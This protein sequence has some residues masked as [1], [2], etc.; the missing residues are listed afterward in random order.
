MGYGGVEVMLGQNSS[1]QPHRALVN[2]INSIRCGYVDMIDIGI[3]LEHITEFPVGMND[4]S[5]S[6]SQKPACQQTV[7]TTTKYT[8]TSSSSL[9]YPS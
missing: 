2:F 1:A 6:A 7:P 3:F 5:F 9:T 8:T 4:E